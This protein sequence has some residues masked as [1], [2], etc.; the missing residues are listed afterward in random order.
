M[1]GR[2]LT[3]YALAMTFRE[4]RVHRDPRCPICGDCPTIR[5]LVEID[6]T[7]PTRKEGR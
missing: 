3:Y 4:Y 2:L 1:I 7:C 5:E 6:D